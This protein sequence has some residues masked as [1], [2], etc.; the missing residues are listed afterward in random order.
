M[1]Q[2]GKPLLK[3]ENLRMWFNVRRG[4]FGSPL[5]VR[6]VDGVNFEINVGQSIA[7]VGESG[8]G[9]TTLGKTLLRLYRPTAG[10]ILFDG[11]D[12]SRT[13]EKELKWYRARAQIVYQD[14]FSSLN[15]FFTVYRILEE[16]LIILGFKSPGERRDRILAALRD[17]KL[18][19]VEN[20]ISKYPH[21]LSGGQ[22]QR[23]AI[24][25]AV[26]AHPS[27]LVADEPVS[28]LDA[29][30]RVEILNLLKELQRK[31]DM[32]VLYITHDVATARYFTDEMQIMYAA[33]VVERG[34]IGELIDRPLHPY[35]KALLEA[36]PDPDPANRYKFRDVPVGEPPSLVTPPPGCRYHPRCPYMQ[37]VCREEEP[38]L[39]EASPGHWVA[40]H[41]WDEIESGRLQPS[42]GNVADAKTRAPGGRPGTAGSS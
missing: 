1:K 35:T 8:S 5:Y 36:I 18:Q 30:V 9:K 41:F 7:L 17:V 32:A 37:P 10:R 24:A 23:V 28:M 26:I 39:E 15:P 20:F 22:R 4:F 40:C 14:P 31:Y 38:H 42:R 27:F 3:A 25:R 16:P 34:P 2:D 12:I 11:Q 21:Q 13:D 29:S 33:Q 19:P 6:A